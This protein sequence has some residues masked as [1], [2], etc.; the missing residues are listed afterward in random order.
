MKRCKLLAGLCAGTL[1]L[2][3]VT[4][5]VP[6]PEF[7]LTAHAVSRG[8]IGNNLSWSISNGVVTISG[9]GDWDEN[10]EHGIGYH[11][12]HDICDSITAVVIRNG[13][14]SMPEW[15]KFAEK[16]MS[17]LPD[18]TSDIDQFEMYMKRQDDYVSMLN[19]YVQQCQDELT[20]QLQQLNQLGLIGPK[21]A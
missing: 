3:S 13:V 2:C 1:M 11:D 9:T 6:L 17:A 19:M 4:G 7:T 16:D 12:L 21:Q 15:L 20:A 10:W 18:L 14:T 5:G 8:N